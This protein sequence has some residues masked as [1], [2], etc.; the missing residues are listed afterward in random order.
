MQDIKARVRKICIL[1][2]YFWLLGGQWP[3]GE[4]RWEAMG[5]QQRDSSEM[6]SVTPYVFVEH[7]F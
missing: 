2:R 7:L 4:V 3:G 6:S 5:M 1:E